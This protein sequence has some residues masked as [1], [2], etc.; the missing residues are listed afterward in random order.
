MKKKILISLAI[1]LTI[2]L[3]VWIGRE[4]LGSRLSL[5]LFNM[6]GLLGTPGNIIVLIIVAIVSP[7]EG[8][9]AIHVTFPYNYFGYVA[10]FLFYSSFAYLIQLLIAKVKNRR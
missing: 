5:F 8:W 6:M 1:G 9:Q 4:F 2:T 10:D 3:S 7:Q